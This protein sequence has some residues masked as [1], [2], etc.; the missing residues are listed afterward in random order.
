MSAASSNEPLRLLFDWASAQDN[1]RRL[2]IWIFIALLLH[3][4]V[5]LLLR[6]A[7]PPPNPRPI[8]DAT[9]HVLL[10]GSPEAARLAPFLASADPALFA[11]E[12]LRDLETP[13]PPI[14]NYVPSYEKALPDLVSL[15]EPGT[16][17]L[18]PLTRDFGALPMPDSRQ[19]PQ[20]L[21]P[22]ARETQLEFT[23]TLEGR[24]PAELPPMKF[25]ARPGDLL[26]PTSFLVAV[27]PDGTV[28]HVL[29]SLS[30]VGSTNKS[31]DEA[32]KRYLMSL[33]FS[34]AG[35]M[36]DTTWG[37]ATFPWGLDVERKRLQ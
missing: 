12:Q 30:T 14:P 3:A 24:R 35:E 37:T 7:Y 32:A 16:R 1:R 4:G 19:A 5:Y 6:V 23:A 25:T 26:A 29:K 13:D 36:Q 11:P 33:K 31:L 8:S 9:L 15:P 18:P 20:Q 22:P 27:G 10:P 2:A 28:R 34:P 21:P 17:I